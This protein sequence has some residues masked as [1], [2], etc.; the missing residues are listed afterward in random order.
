MN[1]T[2]YKTADET[3]RLNK[4]LTD[5]IPL[6]GTLREECN[7]LKPTI[8]IQ[9]TTNLSGYNYC[10]VEDFGRY[11]YITEISIIR[12]NLWNI[13]LSVDVLMTY[14]N[15]IKAVPIVA[16]RNTKQY[17]AMLNDNRQVVYE[18]V[19]IQ[20]KNFPKGFSNPTYI[21][22]TSGGN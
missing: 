21:L 1:I 13:S 15:Q 8:K 6:T 14:A 3:N 20:T 9:S 22:T 19:R 5:A 2:L 16:G 18:N 17:N 11:Y 10:Y 4:T 12:T 7:I